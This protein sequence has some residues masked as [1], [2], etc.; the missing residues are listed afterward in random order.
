MVGSTN[1]SESDVWLISQSINI[2]IV[3]F[4]VPQFRL[5]FGFFPNEFLSTSA[6]SV[7]SVTSI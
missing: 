7:A 3:R 1:S 5:L 4:D 6:S 2:S